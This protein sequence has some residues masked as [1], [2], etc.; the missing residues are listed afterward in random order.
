[1]RDAVRDLRLVERV[2]VELF[3]LLALIIG[4]ILDLGSRGRGDLARASATR[5]S[6]TRAQAAERLLAQ[7]ASSAPK[8]R[9]FSTASRCADAMRSAASS[10]SIRRRRSC[11]SSCPKLVGSPSIATAVTEAPRE[12]GP[13]SQSVARLRSGHTD[14][15][16]ALTASRERLRGRS[17]SRGARVVAVV[18]SARAT[19]GAQ[20][21]TAG[22]PA[23]L[24]R[25]SRVASVNEQSFAVSPLRTLVATSFGAAARLHCARSVHASPALTNAHRTRRA[26]LARSRGSGLSRYRL[27][28]TRI[29]RRDVGRRRMGIDR[30]RSGTLQLAAVGPRRQGRAGRGGA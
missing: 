21:G 7:S 27:E 15:Q 24:R 22:A 25:S 14:S 30:E 16:H 8:L 2:Q 17:N 3:G 23:A 20:R 18:V 10:R 11:G 1:M 19:P 4:R 28:A 9:T 12:R 6:S 26:S 29:R 5:P 13:R